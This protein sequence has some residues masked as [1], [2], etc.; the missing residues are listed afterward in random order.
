MSSV[1][2]P[3][4]FGAALALL[5]TLGQTS[6]LGCASSQAV[7]DP[8]PA[9]L[10]PGARVQVNRGNQWQPATVVRMEGAARV[11]VHYDG[12]GQEWDETLPLDRVRFQSEP[13]SFRDY[14]AGEVVLVSFQG[15]LALATIV[16]QI[17][18]NVWR[19]HYDGYGSQAIEEVPGDR[20]RRPYPGTSSHG[21][22]EAVA[23]HSG[24]SVRPAKVVAIVAQD[25]WLV[26]YDGYGPGY[27]E[28][29][30]AAR[31]Y[32]VEGSPSPT[33][34]PS[35][36]AVD[37][38]TEYL[39]RARARIDRLWT[40]PAWAAAK[41]MRATV[42]V[43]FAVQADGRVMTA[44]VTQPSG[45]PEFDESCRQAVLRAGPYEPL[46]P[47][48]GPSLRATMTFDGARAPA[49]AR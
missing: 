30:G 45:I 16:D 3:L 19:V 23:V 42:I 5:L 38:R 44:D 27:D 10:Q 13:P 17:S 49:P 29:V 15:R 33:A 41:G 12:Y 21:V 25:R 2:G 43:T 46:P 20:L 22:G 14:R 28:E 39:G 9:T 36:P 35:V 34:S 6:G 11:R 37:S 40:F 31:L 32:D 48:L 7:P 1:P 18:A 47:E 8:F 24:G 4:R 26:R